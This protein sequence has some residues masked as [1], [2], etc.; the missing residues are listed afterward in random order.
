MRVTE[1]GLGA[2]ADHTKDRVPSRRSGVV[3]TTMLATAEWERI[4]RQET[5]V[6]DV[7]TVVIA[8]EPP[9]RTLGDDTLVP[10]T[11]RRTV[12]EVDPV[13]APFTATVEETRTKSNEVREAS[14]TLPR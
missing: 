10:P 7:Q 12:T 11:A 5:L 4:C 3:E 9:R 14:V 8:A 13:R 6:W 2:S 1:L